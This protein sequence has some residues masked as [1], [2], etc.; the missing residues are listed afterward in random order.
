[1]TRNLLEFVSRFL[2]GLF[3]FFLSSVP[4]QA[5]K[6]YLVENLDVAEVLVKRM[7]CSWTAVDIVN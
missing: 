6:C 1:M 5:A 4:C 2:S 3:D 7:T